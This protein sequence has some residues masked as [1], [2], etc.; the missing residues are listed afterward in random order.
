MYSSVNNYF[1]LGLCM[2]YFFSIEE[3]M[4]VHGVCLFCNVCVCNVLN[5]WCDVEG[6]VLFYFFFCPCVSCL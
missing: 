6:V 2:C 5:F 4:Y 1:D 3:C